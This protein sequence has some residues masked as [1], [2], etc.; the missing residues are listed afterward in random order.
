LDRALGKYIIQSEIGRGGMGVV[1]K[2]RDVELDRIVAM[3]VL[4][5]YLV[6]EPRLVQRFIREA[7]LAANLDHANIVTIYDIGG[8]GGYY[9]FVMKHLEGRPL[10][11]I[12]A[13]RGP[14]PLEEVVKLLL[15]M[16][17]ALDYAHRENLIHRDIKPGNVIVGPDGHATLTD[18]GLAKVAENLKLTASGESMGT[19]EYMAP[20]QARGEGGKGS[21]I[22]SLGVMVYEMLAGRLP[23]QGQ[24]QASLLY[25]H[26]HEPPPPMQ[27]WRPEIPDA[28][29]EVV[30]K[31]MAKEPHDR[32]VQAGQF[33]RDLEKAATEA[34]RREP[35]RRRA[36]QEQEPRPARPRIKRERVV[37]L[38]RRRS[39]REEAAAGAEPVSRPPPRE[40]AATRPAPKPK[41]ARRP[42]LSFLRPDVRRWVWLGLGLFLLAAILLGGVLLNPVLRGSTPTPLPTP[43]V[44]STTTYTR[45]FP[46]M[47]RRPPDASP[48]PAAQITLLCAL[49]EEWGGRLA[50]WELDQEEAGLWSDLAEVPI[51]SQLSWSPQGEYLVFVSGHT[52]QPQLS[53][54]AYGDA[55][56]EQLSG[57]GD[58]V[59]DPAWSPDGESIAYACGPQGHRRICVVPAA[60]GEI[61]H[62]TPDDADDWA[63]SWAPDGQRL[64][65]VSNRDGNTEI[66][67]LDLADGQIYRLTDN[68]AED[69]YPSWSPD[70]R[71]IAFLSDRGDGYD[72]Y[73][74]DV[75]GQVVQK[76]LDADFWLERPAWSPKGDWLAFTRLMGNGSAQ[77]FLLRPY[78]GKI[79]AGPAGCRRPAWRPI[80]GMI[81]L[82]VG[83]PGPAL[84]D[85]IVFPTDY[86]VP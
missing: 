64:A 55:E 69:L 15:Q 73:R 10:K 7:R 80:S 8:E 49:D 38:P 35:A 5:P 21:D 29:E 43:P 20:E 46:A 76:L 67:V 28:V 37:R 44:V 63:P 23:F 84:P 1:Y 79:V 4:S 50:T 74:T 75:D 27:Q 59:E 86:P 81:N 30:L 60:G 13:E 39:K 24:S 12:L 36:K 68:P 66:H 25:Q 17:S 14:L 2:A 82:P 31:A 32:Y 53:R 56:P 51:L 85:P 34:P 9:Y 77:V 19:L 71:Q 52:G 22:Y 57:P 3:K 62:L 26:L 11:E 78:D 83:Y 48:P 47:G 72:L 58:E 65:F 42:L 16:G 45:Y 70:G 18:F 40:R 6:G 41:S 54:M 61:R 33:A